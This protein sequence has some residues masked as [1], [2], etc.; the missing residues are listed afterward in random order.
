MVF[1]AKITTS[2]LKMTRVGLLH[3]IATDLVVAMYF[4]S[5]VSH[6]LSSDHMEICFAHVVLRM[7]KEKTNSAYQIIN[8]I[9]IMSRKDLH[10][11]SDKDSNQQYVAHRQSKQTQLSYLLSADF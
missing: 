8:I 1:V 7:H 2:R 5:D 9:N 10:D 11:S 4:I 3:R 6:G